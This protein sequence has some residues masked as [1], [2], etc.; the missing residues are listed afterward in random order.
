MTSGAVRRFCY[1][2]SGQAWDGQEVGGYSSTRGRNTWTVALGMLN[3]PYEV[4]SELMGHR[5][6][7]IPKD[8][9]ILFSVLFWRKQGKVK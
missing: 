5:D 8:R 3:M 6:R 9:Y 1:C 7:V 2:V 4:T